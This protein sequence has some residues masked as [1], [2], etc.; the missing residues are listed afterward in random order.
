M[1]FLVKNGKIFVKNNTKYENGQNILRQ[2]WAN[3]LILQNLW[4]FWT[5]IFIRQNIRQFFV[6]GQIYL[7]IHLWYFSCRIYLEI[8][9]SNVYG[10]EYIWIFIRPKKSY[11]YTIHWTLY[12][13]H[14]TLH[15]EN[16]KC[17]LHTAHQVVP[18]REAAV[19]SWV[20]L[21]S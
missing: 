8:H 13:A 21:K 14:W 4:I 2:F 19:I 20:F 3:Y 12:T 15:N 11:S 7:D 10:N 17:I 16:Y 6:V 9:S 1:V 5:N 18:W